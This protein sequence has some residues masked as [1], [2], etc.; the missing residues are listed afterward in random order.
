MRDIVFGRQWGKDMYEKPV[1]IT[2]VVKYNGLVW[3]IKWGAV[4]AF[5]V[6]IDRTPAVLHFTIDAAKQLKSTMPEELPPLAGQTSGLR[7]LS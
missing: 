6:E 5:D 3:D 1:V 7:K 4:I 2:N